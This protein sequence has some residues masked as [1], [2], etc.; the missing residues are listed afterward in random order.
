MGFHGAPM[1]RTGPVRPNCLNSA[2]GLV[3]R[4]PH[5]FDKHWVLNAVVESWHNN[6][7]LKRDDE[8]EIKPDKKAFTYIKE[9][10]T[11]PEL[12]VNL[13]EDELCIRRAWGVWVCLTKMDKVKYPFNIYQ[14]SANESFLLNLMTGSTTR[15][16]NDMFEQKR[17]PAEYQVEGKL[18]KLT[19]TKSADQK[20]ADFDSADS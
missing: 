3:L 10:E 1:G 6:P 12:V 17:K 15:F 7:H 13:T 18:G 16:A 9:Q 19:L 11:K 8:L 5:E 2:G 20:A 4:A 14:N